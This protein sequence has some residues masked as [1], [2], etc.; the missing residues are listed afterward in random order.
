MG[1]GNRKIEINHNLNCHKD[2][3]R[4]LLTS[5]EGI[6]HRSRRPIE[7]ETVFGQSKS[8]KG[9]SRFRHFNKASRLAFLS[10]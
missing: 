5:T 4:Q 10:T 8:N 1:K 9:Y 2:R 3:V 7:P 6:Y